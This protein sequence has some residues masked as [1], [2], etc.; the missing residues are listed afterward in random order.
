MAR[1]FSSGFELQSATSGIEVDNV[2]GPTVDTVLFHGGLASLQTAGSIATMDTSGWDHQFSG[3]STRVF[4]RYYFYITSLDNSA[5]VALYMD[6]LSSTT[7]VIS[8]QVSNVG[9]TYTVT[10]YY[11]NFGANLT[12]FN[13]S[14][15]PTG[16][17]HYLEIEYDSTPA[18]ASEVLRVRLDG[19]EQAAATNLTYTNKTVNI[20]GTGVF[21]GTGGSISGST[22]NYDDFAINDTAAGSGQTS[23]PGEGYIAHMH[24]GGS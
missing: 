24:P 5:S 1:L 9:G 13:I 20:A 23:Y 15:S 17:W 21:N 14:S 18:N 3:G 16:A 19:V 2:Y 7:N 4:C 22:V 12:P 11:N 8:C 10:P 6:L